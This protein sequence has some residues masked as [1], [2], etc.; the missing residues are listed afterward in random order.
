[1]AILYLLIFWKVFIFFLIFSKYNQLI[2]TNF[3]GLS[4]LKV[5]FLRRFTLLYYDNCIV[6][7]SYTV[8]VARVSYSVWF[9]G[10][11]YKFSSFL[12]IISFKYCLY[13][14]NTFSRDLH[15]L[16]CAMPDR[17]SWFCKVNA[18]YTKYSVRLP[19]VAASIFMWVY[20]YKV[21]SQITC[22]FG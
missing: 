21:H 15:H 11:V 9:D 12:D 20:F 7:P 16:S 4:T 17:T 10:L 22:P 14:V 2:F 8:I 18:Y 6:P 1:M 19:S 13:R 3:H 5:L